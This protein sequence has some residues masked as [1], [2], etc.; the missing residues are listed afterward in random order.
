[1]EDPDGIADIA[2]VQI[3][4]NEIGLATMDMTTTATSGI[5]GMYTTGEIKI[6]TG[7]FIGVKTLNIYAR[8][9]SGGEG[10]SGVQIKVT[11]INKLG[12]APKIAE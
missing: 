10:E 6:P 12:K 8:D 9:K 1:M 2:S 5:G 4:L 7:T 11:N 3:D